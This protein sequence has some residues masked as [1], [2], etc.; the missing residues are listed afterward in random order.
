M[1]VQLSILRLT[2]VGF[3]S[4]L[5]PSSFGQIDNFQTLA[6]QL[7][8]SK[9]DK[10]LIVHADDVGLAHS[11]NIATFDALATGRVNSASII[12]PCPWLQEVADFARSKPDAD[13]GLHLTLTSEW[14][15][16]RWGPVASKKDVPSLVSLFGYFYPIRDALGHMKPQ[17]VE[18]ELKAQIR[19]A[20]T[21]GIEPSHLDSHQLLLFFRPDLFQTYLRVGREAGLPILLAKGVFSII[22]QRMGES[23]PDFESFLHSEDIVIGDVLSISPEEASDGW[24]AFYEKA[25]SN[26]R[27]G[28]SQLIV[29]LGIDNEEMRGIAGDLPFGA[30]WRQKE[31]DFLTSADFG[32][33]LSKND[34][35]MI[36]WRDIAN[37]KKKR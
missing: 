30:S 37:L 2:G 26:L 10:L 20:R 36:A 19:L 27:P 33:L 23:A 35:K 7:G 9:S 32:R 3:M 16:Y 1:K 29:H 17:E 14:H 11:V 28:V 4:M 22:R 8:Y 15:P 25:L 6:E 31:L 18:I 21:M 13:F 24:P 12:V 34:I 5:L